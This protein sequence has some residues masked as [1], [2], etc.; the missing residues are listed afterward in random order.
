[1]PKVFISHASADK[2]IV[3]LFKDIILKGGI[4]LS[5]ADIFFTSSPET[6]VPIGKNIPEYIKKN[7]RDCDYAFLMIS[8]NYK[9]SEVCLNEMGAAMVLSK[10]LFP[11]LLY[12]Y[13]FDKV[14]WLIDRDL[15]AMIDDQERL[16][17]IRDIFCEDGIK[18]CTSV[19]NKSR[20]S[21]IESIRPLNCIT[22]DGKT[23]KGYVDYQIEIEDSLNKYNRIYSDIVAVSSTNISSINAILEELNISQSLS[24]QKMLLGHIAIRFNAMADYMERNNTTVKESVLRA[25]DSVL[26]IFKYVRLSESDRETWK[27]AISYFKSATLGQKAEIEKVK[28]LVIAFGDLEER[29]IEAKMRVVNCYDFLIETCNTSIDKANQVLFK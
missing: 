25:L 21:F 18:T 4:G 14:G 22:E 20:F 12:D 19:W 15:C 23:T 9:K 13:D 29:Q 2:N 6:G 1:M 28:S 3:C 27:N 11:I 8:E 5:D 16:D 7:L 17:E 26:E 24:E 10:R